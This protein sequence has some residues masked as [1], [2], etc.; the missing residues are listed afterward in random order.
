MLISTA[1]E[2]VRGLPVVGNDYLRAG[3]TVSGGQGYVGE[4]RAHGAMSGA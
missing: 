1:T 2:R 3:T 4:K